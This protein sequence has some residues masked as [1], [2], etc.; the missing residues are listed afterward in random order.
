MPSL[1]SKGRLADVAAVAC[2]DGLGRHRA[3]QQVDGETIG[4][5]GI[6]HMITEG[7]IGKT[8]EICITR[9]FINS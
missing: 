8:I 3:L 6:E 5:W 7:N 4:F 9:M 2:A 1:D